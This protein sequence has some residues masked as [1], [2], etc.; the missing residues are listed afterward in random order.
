MN[1]QVDSLLKITIGY[2]TNQSPLESMIVE[3]GLHIP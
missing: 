3:F 2:S 1:E